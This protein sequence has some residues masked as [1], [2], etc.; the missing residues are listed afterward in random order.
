M[1][2]MMITSLSLGHHSLCVSV[3]IY[4]FELAHYCCV[5][6]V[7]TS[8]CVLLVYL[9][10]HFTL[11]FLSHR[12]TLSHTHTYTFTKSISF[13]APT[14][15]STLL[16]RVTARSIKGNSRTVLIRKYREYFVI[17]LR[18]TIRWTQSPCMM[19]TL[20]NT[21]FLVPIKSYT[22]WALHRLSSGHW[23]WL[24]PLFIGLFPNYNGKCVLVVFV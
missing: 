17:W 22:S 9:I 6:A 7:G 14:I 24:G 23:V 4:I 5:S 19:S 3:S 10:P 1:S 16:C 18:E 20:T 12:H 2:L 13:F 21:Q 15:V 8:A 11:F